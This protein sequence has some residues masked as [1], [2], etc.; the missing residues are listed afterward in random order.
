MKVWTDDC[1]KDEDLSTDGPPNESDSDDDQE[2][3]RNASSSGWGARD[4]TSQA[5]AGDANALVEQ[6]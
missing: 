2:K 6:F 1:A 4:A 5:K 3:A